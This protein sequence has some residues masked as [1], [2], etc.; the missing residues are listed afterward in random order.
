MPFSSATVAPVPHGPG[1][2]ATNDISVSYDSEELLFKILV[3]GD[4]GVGKTAIIRRYTEGIFSQN[5]KLTI[6]V[7]F[8]LKTLL[9][10]E[11]THV[12][13]Q[14]W[15]IAGHERFGYMTHVYYKYAAAAIIVFD[16][17]RPNTLDS[18]IKWQNDIQDKITQQNGQPLPIILIANKCDLEGVTIQC[19]ELKRFCQERN[20]PAWFF[21][22]A[23][24]NINIKEAIEFMVDKIIQ[25]RN[26]HMKGEVPDV[27]SGRAW[28]IQLRDDGSKDK[29]KTSKCCNT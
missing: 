18:V 4:F 29:L 13:L 6:G 10:D 8:A 17:S 14:L 24:E 26:A 1:T 3:I 27:G 9:W 23:K 11:K 15:D 21:T 20:I 5:Y 25:F 19:S 7:D 2:E 12:T 28:G 16:L 22:S